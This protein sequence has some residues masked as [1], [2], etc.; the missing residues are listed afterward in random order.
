MTNKAQGTF[1]H[2]I[3]IVGSEVRCDVC[4]CD[5]ER[6]RESRVYMCSEIVLVACWRV[7]RLCLSPPPNLL[8]MENEH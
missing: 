6:E 5:H 8:D 3:D 2:L 4:V 7:L 1:L